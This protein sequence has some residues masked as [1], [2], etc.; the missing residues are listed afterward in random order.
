MDL[1]PEG[2]LGGKTGRKE[3]DRGTEGGGVGDGRDF[4]SIL[5]GW[6]PFP[7]SQKKTKRGVFH[8]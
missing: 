2:C 6:P 4:E 3:G 8:V 7:Q 1:G 5:Y